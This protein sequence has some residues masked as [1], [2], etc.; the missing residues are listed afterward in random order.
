[1]LDWSSPFHA[2]RGFR[3]Q[4]IWA[5]DRTLVLAG[6]E[7]AVA[8][9][10]AP[11][12]GRVGRKTASVVQR[13]PMSSGWHVGFHG[14]CEV[15]HL[16]DCGD[17][18]FALGLDF[19]GGGPERSYI[20]RSD[21]TGRAFQAVEAPDLDAVRLARG[22][23]FASPEAG[24]V[25]SENALLTTSDRGERWGASQD[26]EALAGSLILA[27]DASEGALWLATQSA[28]LLATADGRVEPEALPPGIRPDALSY[29]DGTLWAAGR[30]T[31]AQN[32]RIVRRERAGDWRELSAT[33]RCLPCRLH[34]KGARALLFGTDVAQTPPRDVLLQSRDGGATWEGEVTP[35]MRAITLPAGGG[36]WGCGPGGRVV[37]APL[38]G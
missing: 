7:I 38:G 30:S 29:H 2:P 37:C 16:A 21:S 4:S 9:G 19:D 8:A 11:P 3:C 36:V 18:L 33:P 15:T 31:S 5:G 20:V 25:W 1:M 22:L 12:R 24:Y 28:L 23:A 35:R 13:G 14:P 6:V 27:W 10:P 26:Y 32:V 34:R 17:R